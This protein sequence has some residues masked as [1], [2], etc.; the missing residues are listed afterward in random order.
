MRM[1]R[2]TR[3]GEDDAPAIKELAARQ[4]SNEHSRVTLL[5]DANGCDS[6]FLSACQVFLLQFAS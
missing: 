1:R 3:I 2:Q 4:D 5:G 6:L